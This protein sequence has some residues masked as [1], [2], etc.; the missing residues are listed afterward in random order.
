MP[1]SNVKQVNQISFQINNVYISPS[2]ILAASTTLAATPAKVAKSAP[3]R[4]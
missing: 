3:G 2:H 4:V 1:F